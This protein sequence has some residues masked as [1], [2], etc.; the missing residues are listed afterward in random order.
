MQSRPVV[1]TEQPSE[2]AAWA[3]RNTEPSR[4]YALY[5]R[6]NYEARV[7]SVLSAQSVET[8]VPTCPAWS[9]RSRV[10]RLADTPIFPGYVF[11]HS[12]LT[13][14]VWL[15]VKKTT[16]V[17]R[18]VG[19][20]NEPTPIPDHEIESLRTVLAVQPVVVGHPR[21]RAG[22]HVRVVRGPLAGV[23]GTLVHVARN[24][25]RLVITVELLNRS[26]ST[27]IDASLVEPCD[28]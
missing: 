1:A 10:P 2:Q 26:V 24:R 7:A 23:Y 20:G 12:P 9:R 17:V 25:H 22:Q 19:C 28:V 27:S 3:E 18:I 15:T 21:L 8:Y 11:I 16:G 6:S 5:T 13:K 4:W 14:E